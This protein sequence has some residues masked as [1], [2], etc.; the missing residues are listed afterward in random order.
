MEGRG[1]LVRLRGAGVGLQPKDIPA[2]RPGMP[3]V[4]EYGTINGTMEP[5]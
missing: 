4:A 1:A 3:K 5:W 2:A